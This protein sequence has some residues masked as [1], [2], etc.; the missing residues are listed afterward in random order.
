[1][2]ELPRSLGEDYYQLA[3]VHAQLAAPPAEDEPV[4]PPAEDAR[5][6]DHAT[7]AVELLRQASSWAT[8][9]ELDLAGDPWL[10]HLTTR[11]DFR[12]L[13]AAPRPALGAAGSPAG[14]ES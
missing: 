12:R 4:L 6:G 14:K 5:R 10:A 7:R 1:L 13:A 8:R 2:A 9:P 11:D 3:V